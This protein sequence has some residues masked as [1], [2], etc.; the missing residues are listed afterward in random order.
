MKKKISAMYLLILCI[1]ITIKPSEDN[2]TVNE[3]P[4]F[5]TPKTSSVEKYE[6]QVNETHIEEILQK[7]N[8]VKK[9]DMEQYIKKEIQELKQEIVNCNNDI[10]RAIEE[11]IKNY[12]DLLKKISDKEQTNTNSI[13]TLDSNIQSNNSKLNSIEATQK[14]IKTVQEQQKKKMDSINTTLDLINEKELSKEIKELSKEIIEVIKRLFSDEKKEYEK[15]MNTL[16]A[17]YVLATGSIAGL[18]YGAYKYIIHKKKS[19]KAKKA[20]ITLPSSRKK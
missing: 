12:M 14:D 10:I 11:K 4:P 2:Q 8:L 18:V 3:Y 6:N 19:A 13:Q 20:N 1:G 5:S 7:M 16:L 15:Y 17:K 9:T